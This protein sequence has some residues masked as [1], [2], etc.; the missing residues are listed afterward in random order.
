MRPINRLLLAAGCAAVPA[1]AHAQFGL[2]RALANISVANVNVQ[3][4]CLTKSS[5]MRARGG[6]SCGL[7]G[8]G[9]ELAIDLSPDS[10]SVQY[11]FALGY[12]QITGFTSSEPTMDVHGVMRL[13]PEASLYITHKT[14]SIVQPYIG[15]HTGLVSLSNVQVYSVPGDTSYSF[16]AST[17]QFGGTGGLALPRGFYV[18]VGYRYR[19]FESLEWRLPKG[20]LPPHWPKSLVMSA[21][22]FTAGMQFDVGAITGKKK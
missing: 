7:Y 21:V 1:A 8:W 18:D 13:Q 2:D 19:R 10:A 15:L 20:N 22:Q 5:T 11:Q 12:G 16:S 6:G 14:S 17:L 4:S 3:T 9:L